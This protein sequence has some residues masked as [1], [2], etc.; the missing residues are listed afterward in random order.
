MIAQIVRD[1]AQYELKKPVHFREPKISKITG[2]VSPLIGGDIEVDQKDF[3]AV[4][5]AIKYFDISDGQG[6]VWHCRALPCMKELFG[7]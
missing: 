6:K 1:L 2:M 7:C 3:Q 4:G 5:K